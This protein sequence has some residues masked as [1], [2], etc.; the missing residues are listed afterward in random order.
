MRKKVKII[1]TGSFVIISLAL[2][3]GCC[4][5]LSKSEYNMDMLSKKP[6][7]GFKI[8]NRD[9]TFVHQGTTPEYVV[10]PAQSKYFTGEVYKIK[11][12]DGNERTI[13]ATISPIYWG[14]VLGFVGFFV[15]GITGAMWALPNKVNLDTKEQLL[16]DNKTVGTN[17]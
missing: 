6:G 2:F 1:L 13:T 5:S 4:T 10:L 11:A 8:T 12:D 17:F 15:D 7:V 16:A 3:S 9:G 14:N